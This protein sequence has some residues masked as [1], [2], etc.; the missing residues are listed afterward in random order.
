MTTQITKVRLEEIEK[1]HG[2]DSRDLCAAFKE[3]V[4]VI[5]TWDCEA[6]EDFLKRFDGDGK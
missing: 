5:R 1:G 4:K 3:A 2:G 6:A